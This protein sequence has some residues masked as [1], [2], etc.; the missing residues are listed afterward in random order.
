MGNGK[1]NTK[2]KLPP[3]VF[4]ERCNVVLTHSTADF[5][6]L[7]GAVALAKLWCVTKPSVPTHVVMPRGANPMV[8]RFLMYHKH[9]FPIRGMKTIDPRDLQDIGIV[10]AQEM[11]RIGSASDWLQHA[12]S[13]SVYDHHSNKRCNLNPTELVIEPV[14]SIT[15]AIVERLISNS[16]QLTREEATLFALGIRA[17]TG[18]LTYE[19]TTIRDC[20][21]LVWLMENGVSRQAIAEFGQSRLSPAHTNVLTEALN[22]VVMRMHHGV[23]LASV[24]VSTDQYVTGL[25]RVAMEVLELTSADVLLLGSIHSSGQTSYLSLIGRCCPSVVTVQLDEVMEQVSGGGHAKAAAATVRLKESSDGGRAEA[26]LIMEKVHTLVTEQIPEEIEAA[27]IMRT[28][29]TTVSEEA[30]MAEAKAVM[31]HH[32]LKGLPVIRAAEPIFVGFLKM[33]DIVKAEKSGKL[34]VIVKARMRDHVPTVP[35]DMRMHELEEVL[36]MKGIGRLPVV[37]EDGKLLGLIT[38]TDVLRQHNLYED[39]SSRPRTDAFA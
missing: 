31:L 8:A 28:G 23:S 14:G 21:A 15:T 13:I 34:N 12:S 7:A 16:I 26:D 29:V 17:D 37:A 25:A 9:L 18:G 2:R 4:Q 22:K 32:Q 20:K 39:G 1:G 3:P 33:I 19:H 38:R 10:D 36:L 5:D 27:D 35:P 11:E 24:L 30:T 6:S